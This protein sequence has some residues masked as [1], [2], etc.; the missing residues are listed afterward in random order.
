MIHKRFFF[1]AALFLIFGLN[2][3]AQSG[4]PRTSA[5]PPDTVEKISTEEIKLNVLAYDQNDNFVADLKAEDLVINE[6][7]RLMQATS[8]R[9]IPANVLFLLDVGGEITYAKR[10]RVT[11]E[12]AMSLV[13]SLRAEDSVAVLQY[14]DKVDVLSDWT[15]SRA[16]LAK[17]LRENKLGFGRRSAFVDAMNKAIEY[18][19][20]TPLENRHLIL[21]S[22][23]IDSFNDAA[24]RS[25]MTKK[26]LSS[27]INVH[28]ISYTQ[29]QQQAVQ[30]LLNRKTSPQKITLPPGA[31]KPH[32]RDTPQPVQIGPVI[33]LDREM[34]RKRKEQ[35]AQ[36]KTSEAYLTTIAEDTNG[37]IYLP[38]SDD[39]M[40]DK[41]STLAKTIDSQ[42]VVTYIPKRPLDESPDGEVRLIEVTS[43]R[44]GLMIQGKRK[45][46]VSNKQ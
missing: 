4:R 9:R 41:T 28:V 40:K 27:D 20:E 24:A 21:I 32:S 30:N 8:L 15:R 29:L 46:I 39:E 33:N 34:V 7:D 36:L 35:A 2:V 43:R 14:G 16:D 17:V 6:D 1:I 37:E 25:A 13:S 42:Y 19:N 23:G 3:F 44:P 26:L 11:A 45:F 18:F 38:E 12:T 22:D 10:N 5:T 31:E